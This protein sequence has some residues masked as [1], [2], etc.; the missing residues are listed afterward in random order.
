MIIRTIVEFSGI[1]IRLKPYLVSISYK[2]SSI[3]SIVSNSLEGGAR[4]S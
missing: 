4:I 2:R 1:R 3:Y